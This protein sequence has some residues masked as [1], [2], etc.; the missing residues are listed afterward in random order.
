MSSLSFSGHESFPCRPFW[1]KKGFDFINNGHKFNE[2][3]AVEHLGVG[4]NMVRSIKYWL[5]AFDALQENDQVSDL[6]EKLLVENGWDPFLED[7]GTLWLL[8]YLIL[9]REHASAY[10]IVFSELRKR[11]PEFSRKNFLQYVTVEKDGT[12]NQATLKTDFSVFIRTY[13]DGSSEQIEEGY[14]ALLADLNLLTLVSTTTKESVY[15]IENKPRAVPHQI[16]LYSIL[17]NEHYGDS[18]SFDSLYLDENGPGTVFALDREGLV[19]RL[20]QI[21]KHYPQEVIF[22][23]D[24]LIRELQFKGKKLNALRVLAGYYKANI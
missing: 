5:K 20:E 7:T 2:P 15:H 21:A 16:V 9:K 14:S 24:P 3:D 11:K 6:F 12:F 18:I 4:N 13:F 23:K 19:E 22:K 1:L 17:N 10:R 8:H